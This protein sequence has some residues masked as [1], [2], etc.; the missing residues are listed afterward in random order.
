MIHVETAKPADVSAVRGIAAEVFSQYGDYARI[1]PRFFASPGVQTYLAR[2][3]QRV[4]GF[5]MIGF[6]PWSGKDTRSDSWVGDVLALAVVPEA[7]R[8]GV[9]T[10]LMQR[11]RE[12]ARDLGRERV[13]R[14]LQLTCART[15]HA[16]LAFFARLGFRVVDPAHGWYSGGQ[17]AL[18]MAGS[19]ESEKG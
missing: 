1:L 7:R 13:I 16:A 15:N 11:A 9:G 12:L 18:R 17:P 19:L 2:D 5:V 8:Q 14:E 3:E 6:I 10:R 4:L